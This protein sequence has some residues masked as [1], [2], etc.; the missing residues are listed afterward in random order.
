MDVVKNKRKRV[1]A[2]NR[3]SQ[4]E[5]RQDKSLLF[6]QNERQ[7]FPCE[8]YSE[9]EIISSYGMSRSLS[10]QDITTENSASISAGIL[11]LLFLP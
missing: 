1:F 2:R 4:S 3:T 10:S 11:P 5:K 8:I 9:A 7:F 6:C